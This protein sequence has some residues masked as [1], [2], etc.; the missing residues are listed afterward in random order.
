[1]ITS[2]TGSQFPRPDHWCLCRWHH[3]GHPPRGHWLPPLQT[4][5]S[6]CQKGVHASPLLCIPG[7]SAYIPGLCASCKGGW[8]TRSASTEGAACPP[9]TTC[10]TPLSWEKKWRWK[11]VQ[12]EWQMS[13]MAL[14]EVL[15]CTLS[16]ENILSGSLTPPGYYFSPVQLVSP[17]NERVC[18]HPSDWTGFGGEGT[19]GG[20]KQKREVGD[21]GGPKKM[22]QV[23]TGVDLSAFFCVKTRVI[24]TLYLFIPGLDPP[25]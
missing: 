7:S 1:M 9:I 10:R 21:G 24:F 16:S 3:W 25:D 14:S 18:S 12:Q 6:Y 20:K 19:L 17:Q 5:G 8:G 13:I 4:G 15:F 2:Q 22:P 11:V 23:F